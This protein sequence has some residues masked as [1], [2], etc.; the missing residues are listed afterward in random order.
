MQKKRS[1]WL[2]E[3][4]LS[5]KVNLRKTS[6]FSRRVALGVPKW[7]KI[8]DKMTTESPKDGAHVGLGDSRRLKQDYKKAPNNPSWPKDHSRWPHIAPRW[9]KNAHKLAQNTPKMAQEM[10]KM[11]PKVTRTA[12]RRHQDVPKRP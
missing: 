5:H 9:P 11:A 12:P 2:Q 6:S 4:L 8:A 7:P 3:V 10:H 1:Y